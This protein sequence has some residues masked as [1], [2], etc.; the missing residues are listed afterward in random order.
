ML[1]GNF[2]GLSHHKGTV[3]DEKH[4]IR[5]SSKGSKNKIWFDLNTSNISGNLLRVGSNNSEFERLASLI[6]HENSTIKDK[7]DFSKNISNSKFI[8]APS[9]QANTQKEFKEA[10]IIYI[11]YLDNQP[12]EK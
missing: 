5:K 6:L 3:V 2:G 11:E 8:E 1:Q 10:E 12:D 9:I 4:L 7:I